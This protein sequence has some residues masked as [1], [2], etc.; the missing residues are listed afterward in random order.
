MK[1]LFAGIILS[2]ATVVA[3]AMPRP[4]DIENA[5]AARDYQSAKSM[6]QEV[7]RE[8]P[9][10]AK[11][12]LFNAYVLLKADND[13]GAAAA[14]LKTAR[15]LD[16]NHKVQ[17]SALFGRT[18]A[19]LERAVPVQRVAPKPSYA[20][21][22]VATTYVE[23]VG[24][25]ALVKLLKFLFWTTII[26]II[27]YVLY[28]LLTRKRQV[29]SWMDVPHVPYTPDVLPAGGSLQPRPYVNHGRTYDAPPHPVYQ[30]A[31]VAPQPST[32]VV[33]SGNNHGNDLLTGMLISD[34]MHHGSHDTHGHS[35]SNR[36]TYVEREYVAPAPVYEAPRTT[37]YETS[38]SS[39]SSGSDDD[40]KSSSSSSS[41]SSSDSW[42]SSSSYDSG[43]SSSYDSGSSGGGGWD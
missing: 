42:S 37:D 16:T 39:Y 18:V 3:F 33:N 14:E 8:R 38:R 10:S 27:V 32:V 34:M 25:S 43:S 2:L 13:R 12:H 31:Y 17:D 7:L 23:T 40:W 22:P 1:K 19:E 4:S 30:P 29:T 9:D 21:Q 24:D 5:L 15:L 36:D 28:K 11:A 26:G 6:T 35:H 20:S 41:S